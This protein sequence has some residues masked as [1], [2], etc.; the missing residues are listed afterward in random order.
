MTLRLASIES[1]R[2]STHFIMRQKNPISINL[3]KVVNAPYL[4]A[5]PLSSQ[6]SLSHFAA[7]NSLPSAYQNVTQNHAIFIP[8]KLHLPSFK[9]IKTTPPPIPVT[10]SLYPQQTYNVG[11]V[12]EDRKNT[13]PIVRCDGSTIFHSCTGLSTPSHKLHQNAR[14]EKKE[15]VPQ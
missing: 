7:T 9:N 6:T 14:V 15:N 2:K 3:L 5:Y 4:S 11:N 13:M 1:L 12:E 10:H 8:K